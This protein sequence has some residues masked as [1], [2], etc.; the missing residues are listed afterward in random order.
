MP[1]ITE[2]DLLVQELSPAQ[3]KWEYIGREL[4]VK[5]DTLSKIHTNYSDSG[6]CLKIMVNEWLERHCITWKGI[7]AILRTP[8]IGESHLADQLETKYCLSERSSM[9]LIMQQYIIIALVQAIL[10]YVDYKYKAGSLKEVHEQQ[11]H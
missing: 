3:Q 1:L 4:G 9:I 7:I 10:I 2:C 5:E 11:K 6:D 8:H